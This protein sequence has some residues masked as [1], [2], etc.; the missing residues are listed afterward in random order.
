MS[1]QDILA[2]MRTLFALE[3]NY[4]AMERTELA[5]LR[6]G[7][8]LSLIGPSA[9]TVLAYALNFTSFSEPFYVEWIAYAFFVLITFFGVWMTYHAYAGLKNTRQILKKIRDQELNFAKRSTTLD[10]I[11]HELISKEK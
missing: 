3:R 5:Q 6:T 10:K 11:I 8:T 1:E 9:T 2:I 7:L 4:L